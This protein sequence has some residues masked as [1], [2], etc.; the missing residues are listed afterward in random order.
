MTRTHQNAIGE[1]NGGNFEDGGSKRSNVQ[2]TPR[3]RSRN[4]KLRQ[5]REGGG[6]RGD[7]IA[8]LDRSSAKETSPCGRGEVRGPRMLRPSEEGDSRK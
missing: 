2:R 8:A 3:K 1:G 4:A 6:R 5:K 7:Q